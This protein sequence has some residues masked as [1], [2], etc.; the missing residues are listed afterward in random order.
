MA[1]WLAFAAIAAAL[2]IMFSGWTPIDPLLS[3]LVAALI[4][5]SAWYL[6]KDSAHVLLEGTPPNID[7]AEVGEDLTAHVDQVEQRAFRGVE[8]VVEVEQQDVHG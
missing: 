2:V 8:G 1:R 3:F 6:V 4:L 7:V 5:R